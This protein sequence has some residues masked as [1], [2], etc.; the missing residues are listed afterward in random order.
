MTGSVKVCTMP[1]LTRGSVSTRQCRW[2][3]VGQASMEETAECSEAVRESDALWGFERR[4]FSWCGDLAAQL[5]GGV[6]S[7]RDDGAWRP[8]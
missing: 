1:A 3:G 5:S 7:T 8:K 4:Q 6:S 2:A